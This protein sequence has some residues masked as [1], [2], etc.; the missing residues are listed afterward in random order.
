MSTHE[1]TAAPAGDPDD[2]RLDGRELRAWR[3]MLRA[4]AALTKA[5]D[6]ELERAHGLSLVH[7]E[8]L[9]VLH[10]APGRRMRM[11]ELASSVI[12]SRSGL[13]RLVDRLAKDRLLTREACC[14]DARG[15]FA[16]LTDEG[17]RVLAEARRTHLEG[18]RSRFL[19]HF[20][21]EELDRLGDVWD[22]VLPADNDG[23][24]DISVCRT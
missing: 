3:G 5:L 1:H 21:D 19:R 22:R 12:L 8:V 2:P 18:V 4:H 6:A 14:D 24:D 15:S 16:V 13:T 11:S 7:Y 17:V 23:D 20:S 9:M 10:D